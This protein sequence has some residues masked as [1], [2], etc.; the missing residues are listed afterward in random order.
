MKAPGFWRVNGVLPRLLSP[1]AMLVDLAGRLR[2][3][4]ATP[5]RSRLPVVCVGNLVAGGAGKTPAARSIAARLLEMGRRPAFLSRGHGG[6]TSGPHRVNQATDDAVRVGDEPLLLAEV[7]PT[8]ISRNRA[9]GARAIEADGG[10]DVIVMDDGFQNPWLAKDLSL[11]VVDGGFGFGNGRVMPAGPLRETVDEGLARADAVVVVGRDESGAREAVGGRRPVLAAR[12]VPSVEAEAL[13][14]RRVLAFAG[15]GRPEKFFATLEEIGAVVVAGRGFP[16][17][18]RFRGEEIMDLVEAANAAGADLV[19]T[20][21]DHVRLP[22]EARPMARRV[23]VALDWV[24]PER[25]DT[26]LVG[27]FTP[28]PSGD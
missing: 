7:A 12:I 2:R 10:A 20:A 8:W 25:I 26:L 27:L 24:E 17:H 21:K 14:G 3:G 19:T 18:H 6:S 16:D 28:H 9:A 13:A 11:V 23:D 5:Y 22:E 15:I 4:A 1:A